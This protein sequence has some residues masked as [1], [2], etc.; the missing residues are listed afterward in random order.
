MSDLG[1]FTS[2][3]PADYPL[4]YG[5]FIFQF[6][7]VTRAKWAG[8]LSKSIGWYMLLGNTGNLPGK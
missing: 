6:H 5:D 7:C 1:Y 4:D 2:N 3:K 8:M